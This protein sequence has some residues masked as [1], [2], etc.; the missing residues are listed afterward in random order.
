MNTHD[1][2][3]GL[4]GMGDYGGARNV[5]YAAMPSMLTP[6]IAKLLPHIDGVL[7]M[8][9]RVIIPDL[10]SVSPFFVPISVPESTVYV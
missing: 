7:A 10:P 2:R 9:F 4:I 1:V 6:S 3:C 5:P 8:G